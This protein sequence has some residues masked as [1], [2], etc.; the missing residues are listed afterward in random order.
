MG[1]A[2][3]TSLERGLYTRACAILLF[4]VIFD[5][6]K[7]AGLECTM[8][9]SRLKAEFSQHATEAEEKESKEL[10]LK[11][12]SSAAFKIQVYGYN[13]ACQM[14]F[15]SAVPTQSPFS[16]QKISCH[17]LYCGKFILHKVGLMTGWINDW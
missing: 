9:P 3:T 11:A 8:L 13:H 10:V 12:Q 1:T 16:S 2:Y 5:P 7:S 17:V 15:R 6:I 4:C 14:L